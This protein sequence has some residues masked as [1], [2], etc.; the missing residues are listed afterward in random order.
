MLLFDW[1][2]CCCH[3]CCFCRRADL[4]L[5]ALQRQVRTP[6]RDAQRLLT[7]RLKR[8]EEEKLQLQHQLEQQRLLQEQP[9]VQG[10]QHQLSVYDAEEVWGPFFGY[11]VKPQQL[12]P[13]LL[14]STVLLLMM[15]C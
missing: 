3:C 15:V 11:A 9:L 12:L 7:Q 6:R 5:A 13:L 2:G 1:P 10:E 4:R 8:L 14:V